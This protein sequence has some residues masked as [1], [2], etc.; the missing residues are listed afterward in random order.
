MP[1]DA[2]QFWDLAGLFDPC[3]NDSS[4]L[5]STKK[6]LSLVAIWRSPRESKRFVPPAPFPIS[7]E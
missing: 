7:V 1:K 5:G 3:P 2:A 6:M 4:C